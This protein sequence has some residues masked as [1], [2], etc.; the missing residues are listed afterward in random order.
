MV[1]P[2]FWRPLS[3]LLESTPAARCRSR[4]RQPS[5]SGPVV[6]PASV[7]R[8]AAFGCLLLV[9]MGAQTRS[10]NYV[11]ETADPNFARVVSQAAEQYRRD[12]AVAWLGKAMPDWSQPCVMTVQAGPQLGAG[13]ATTFQFQDGEVFGWRMTIQGSQQRIL[14][15]VLPHEITHMV[16]ASYFR[17]PLPRWADE[18]GATT[19]EHASEKN[20]YRRMLDHFLRTGRGIAFNQMFAMTEYPQDIMPLYAEGYSL[21]EYLIQIGGRRKYVEFLADGLKGDDWAGAVHRALRVHGPRHA[22]RHLAGLGEAGRTVDAPSAHRAGGT[23]VASAHGG[24]H[25]R[26]QCT[27]TVG[28]LAKSPTGA[29]RG[30]SRT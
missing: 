22:A 13:G 6:S 28:T 30:P 4:A 19:V 9:A 17:Q 16:F 12:L 18:G 24:R 7:G 15:S 20:K 14:D 26:S 8:I 3:V 2:H 27:R 21:A 23:G 10:A 5:R 29:G 25:W 11:V 1:E